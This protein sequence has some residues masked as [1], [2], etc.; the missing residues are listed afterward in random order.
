M[1]KKF[2]LQIYN[3]SFINKQS[4]IGDWKPGWH[5]YAVW[6]N[7]NIPN[8]ELAMEFPNADPGNIVIPQLKILAIQH[9]MQ[10]F[11]ALERVAFFGMRYNNI[12][13]LVISNTLE[14][15]QEAAAVTIYDPASQTKVEILSFEQIKDDREAVLLVNSHPTLFF[16]RG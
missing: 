13:F 3:Q 10:L 11:D 5:Y 9:P 4:S 12:D 14:K 16:E 15:K 2:M 7:I 1:S 8:P 6:V